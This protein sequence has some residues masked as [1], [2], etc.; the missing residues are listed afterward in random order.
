M[1]A[2]YD[3]SVITINYNSSQHTLNC[4]QTVL[5][6]VSTQLKIQVIVVDNNSSEEDF[7][8]LLQLNEIP[9]VNICRSRYN[10]GFAAGNMFGVQFANSDY[11]F[12]LNNDCELLNDAI[13]VLYDFCQKN[14]NVGLCSPQ[15]ISPQGVP[16]HCSD[17]FPDLSSKFFGTES[18]LVL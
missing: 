4:V 16:Q 7:L 9:H 2:L 3:V 15:L 5:E 18:P 11:Y 12:F 8:N 14:K 1:K 17:Y 6:S 13:S 10:L